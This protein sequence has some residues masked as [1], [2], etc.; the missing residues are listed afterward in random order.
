MKR[1]R[2]VSYYS[3]PDYCQEQFNGVDGVYFVFY[4]ETDQDGKPYDLKK[5]I[6]ET[7]QKLIDEDRYPTTCLRWVLNELHLSFEVEDALTFDIDNGT[8]D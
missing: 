6:V 3:E 7:R 8:F 4:P 2:I 1:A 5:K